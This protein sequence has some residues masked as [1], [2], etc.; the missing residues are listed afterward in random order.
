M[1]LNF[2]K[3]LQ[4]ALDNINYLDYQEFPVHHTE[5]KADHS[6]ILESYADSKWEIV[7]LLNQ[8]F[9]LNTDL[10]NWLNYDQTDE[11]SYFL[12]EVGSNSLHHSEFK[13][14]HKFHLWRGENGFVIGVEQKGAG[15]DAEHVEENKV[16]DNQGAAFDFFRSCKGNIFFDD[17]K[18]AKVVY[19]E[20]KKIK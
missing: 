8:K 17:S 12:N 2:N 5:E 14:P 6:E 19:F 18:N 10:A 1:T 16:M 11:V 4:Q 15:F 3:T 7:N 13:A 20:F 9:N